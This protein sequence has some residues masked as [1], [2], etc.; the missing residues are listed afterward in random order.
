MLI[1]F[2][3]SCWRWES[4]WYVIKTIHIANH[5]KIHSSLPV[6]SPQYIFLQLHS[7]S[8]FHARMHKL[9]AILIW[10]FWSHHNDIVPQPQPS[11]FLSS[12][13]FLANIIPQRISKADT[14]LSSLW[15]PAIALMRRN[16]VCRDLWL[17]I[18]RWMKQWRWGAV[19]TPN[20]FILP[21]A[22]VLHLPHQVENVSLSV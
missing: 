21:V 1:L 19:I 22:Q 9:T 10:F 15:P 16:G 13:R 7:W 20:P 4:F 11:K 3:R 8:R 17:Q 14:L 6:D 5:Q 12:S 18:Q 2:E